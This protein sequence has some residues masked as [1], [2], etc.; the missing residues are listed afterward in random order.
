[1]SVF[2]VKGSSDDVE[3]FD[4]GIASTEEKAKKMIQKLEEEF[5]D[6]F[7]YR[8]YEQTL[9]TLCINDVEIQF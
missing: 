8:Y 4:C 9:D 7:E 6:A 2:Y 1:M 3:E 5:E